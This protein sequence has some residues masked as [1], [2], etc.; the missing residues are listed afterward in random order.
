MQQCKINSDGKKG[1]SPGNWGGE[2]QGGGEVSN[3]PPALVLP[4]LSGRGE[5]LFEEDGC[6]GIWKIPKAE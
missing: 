1:W 6:W 5:A 3:Q 2:T 4:A